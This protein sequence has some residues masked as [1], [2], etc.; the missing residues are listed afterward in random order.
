[1]IAATINSRS[2]VQLL[3]AMGGDLRQ[4]NKSGKTAYDLA[5]ENENT[6]LLP[7]LQ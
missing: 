3:K 6:D 1:M 4:V 5:A 7:L 2:S